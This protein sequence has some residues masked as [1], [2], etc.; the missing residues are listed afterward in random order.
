MSM[1]QILS[2]IRTFD[3]LLELAPLPGSEHPEISWGDYYFYYAPDGQVPHN[4]QPYATIITKNYPND[5]ESRLDRDGRWRLNIHVGA[6]AFTDLVG[7]PPDEID[8][9]GAG[10]S[11]TDSFLPHP[12][13]GA[14]GWVC[15]VNPARAT[16]AGALE[17]LR[18]AHLTDRRRV[19]RRHSRGASRNE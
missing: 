2:E 10:Y 6:E 1:E 5:T 18:V 16:T 11:T 9:S 8:E 17:A 15:V 3:G 19:E 13:Y 7:Y 12:L 14:Y 4:R